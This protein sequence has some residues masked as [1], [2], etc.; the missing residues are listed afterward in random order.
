MKPPLGLVLKKYRRHVKRLFAG[1]GTLQSAAYSQEIIYP[2]QRVVYRPPIYLDGHL[3][4]IA[5]SSAE[6]TKAVEI[7][8]MTVL[9]EVQTPTIAYHFRDAVAINGSIYIG[10]LKLFVASLKPPRPTEVVETKRA[11]L[12]TSYYGAKYFGHWLRDDCSYY[13][14]ARQLDIP[15]LV[16]SSPSGPHVD[17]YK[18]LFGYEYHAL[19]LLAYVDHLTIFTEHHENR[20]RLQRYESFRAIVQAKFPRKE[21]RT[22]VY[23]KRGDHGIPRPIQNEDEIITALMRIGFVVVDTGSA[24]LEQLLEILVDARIVVS[25]EGSHISHCVYAAPLDCGLLV[26]Q[27]PD[28]F[29]A[30]HRI[31]A[32]CLGIRFGFV[33]GMIG[34][35]GYLFDPSEIL[36]VMEMLDGAIES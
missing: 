34:N 35:A 20:L 11:A 19:A 7:G 27:P 1:P 24:P 10:T 6:S 5:G 33:V 22:F 29:A 36:R 16:F 28:R 30:N 26:L 14:L 3:E 2:E 13:L 25:M 23:L 12:A 9:T 32:D 15:A 21:R 18:S 17:G 31:W 4:R 8:R